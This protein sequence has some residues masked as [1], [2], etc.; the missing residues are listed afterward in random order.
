MN[1][2]RKILLIDKTA[3]RKERIA[4]LKARGYA[5]FP[6]LK[7][8]EART[9]CLSG[10]YDLIVVNPGDEQEKALQFCDELRNQC[11]KQLLLMCGGAG[12]DRDYKV[13]TDEA[14]LLERVDRVLQRTSDAGEYA[15][16]A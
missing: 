5:V 16:A 6:A 11:P 10:G 7:L 13:A 15:S 4:A 3:D 9:R 12:D 14:S 2:P 8:D 1:T